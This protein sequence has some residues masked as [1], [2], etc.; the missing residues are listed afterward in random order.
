MLVVDRAYLDL[1]WF[2]QLTEAGVFFVTRMKDGAAYEVA[3]RHS[4]PSQ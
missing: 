2:A 3:Q 1:V 4:A